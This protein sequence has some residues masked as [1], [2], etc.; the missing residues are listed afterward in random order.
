MQG[1][2]DLQI[3]LTAH[4][5]TVEPGRGIS[6]FVADGIIQSSGETILGADNKAGIAAILEAVLSLEGMPEN[7]LELVFTKSEEV[8]NL[9]AVN[10][11][12]SLLKSKVGFSFDTGGEIGNLAIQL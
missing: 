2:S 4:M 12:Y 8:G 7:S 10:L 6:P 9:G 3:L 11:D 5:D 1:K